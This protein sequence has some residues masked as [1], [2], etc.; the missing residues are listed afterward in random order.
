[1]VRIR[2][3]VLESL[4]AFRGEAREKKA[5]E[6]PPQFESKTFSIVRGGKPLRKQTQSALRDQNQEE[7]YRSPDRE[8]L[9]GKGPRK[10][11]MSELARIGWKNYVRE[12]GLS[13]GPM[14][15]YRGPVKKTTLRQR[16]S[17]RL[18]GRRHRYSAKMA[19]RA[20]YFL[21]GKMLRQ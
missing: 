2:E 12:G 3:Q 5:P 15:N 11:W 20:L 18:Q 7:T 10:P 13:S 19:D 6:T 21:R 14:S 9:G 16:G 8:K 17:R 4:K 1:V